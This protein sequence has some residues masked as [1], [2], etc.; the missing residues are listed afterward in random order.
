MDERL[1]RQRVRKAMQAG[2]LPNR[3]P[4][5]LLGGTVS[6]G[7]CA[8]CGE[9]MPGGVELELVF[10]DPGGGK[11]LHVHPRCMTVFERELDGVPRRA[12]QA[13]AGAGDVR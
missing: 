1:L 11:V 8:L 4:D 13:S 10:N 5:E 9:A 12:G 7:Q 3:Y 6:G 2:K